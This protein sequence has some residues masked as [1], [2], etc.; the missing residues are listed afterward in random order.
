MAWNGVA[1]C[2]VGRFRVPQ[3]CHQTLASI[4]TSFGQDIFQD[5]SRSDPQPLPP[6]Y[7]PSPFRSPRAPT[8]TSNPPHCSILLLMRLQVHPKHSKMNYETAEEV[9]SPSGCGGNLSMQS[10]IN[11]GFGNMLERV[12]AS[13]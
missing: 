4:C 8:S 11:H 9:A 7:A 2:V 3:M 13:G 6:R 10:H 1:D 12:P 5:P